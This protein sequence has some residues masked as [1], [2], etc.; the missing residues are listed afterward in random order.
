MPRPLLAAAL[1]LVP[2]AAFAQS[3][4]AGSAA[5]HACCADRTTCPM[6][7]ECGGHGGVVTEHGRVRC[8]TVLDARGLSLFLTDADG[9]PVP[10]RG[11][12]GAAVLRVAGNPKSYRYDL[13]PAA[14][15]DAPPNLLALPLDLSKV[16][17]REVSD[18]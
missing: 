7:G 14:G 17:G 13:F 5:P 12:R 8:E 3:P 11:V 10:A 4:P 16:A 2:P 9:R 18:G 1:L 6:N 15:E